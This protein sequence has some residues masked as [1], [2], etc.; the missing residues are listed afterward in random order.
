MALFTYSCSKIG[1]LQLRLCMLLL[2]TAALIH[3]KSN[4][5]NDVQS[6]QLADDRTSIAIH[7]SIIKALRLAAPKEEGRTW[8]DTSLAF[9]SDWLFPTTD[10]LWGVSASTLP[11]NEPCTNGPGCDPD[12]HRLVCTTNADCIDPG[13]NCAP[14]LATVKKPGDVPLNLCQYPSDSMVDG[15]YKIMT[16]AEERLDIVSLAAPSGIFVSA[17]NNAL[18]FLSHRNSFTEVRILY[19]GEVTRKLN[20]NQPPSAYLSTLLAGLTKSGAKLETLKIDVGWLS[21]KKALSWNH[22]KLIIADQKIVLQGGHNLWDPDYIGLRPVSDMSMIGT[23]AGVVASEKFVD[24]LWSFVQGAAVHPSQ[25]KV[26]KPFADAVVPQRQ[27]G[28]LSVLA[29]GRLGAYNNGVLYPAS[30]GQESKQSSD[31]ALRALIDAA[32][33]EV[34]IAQQDLYNL[35]TKK[36]PL[37]DFST[38]EVVG[39]FGASYAAT[40]IA[41]AVLRGVKFNIIQSNAGTDPV[42]DYGTVSATDAFTAL[43]GKIEKVAA[44]IK[45]IPPPGKTLRAY[46]CSQ[47]NYA[48]FR[49][50]PS[51]DKWA[52]GTTIGNHTK[53][54]IADRAAFYIGSHNL[55]PFDLQEFGMITFD[56]AR[57]EELIK[58]YWVPA[59]AGSSPSKI[60]CPSGA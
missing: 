34:L 9:S 29:V 20:I 40:N 23:G 5:A 7:D 43:V 53:I 1:R 47:V 6:A 30:R 4:S 12:F 19:S 3:C 22:A 32:Q 8:F 51:W 59:W 36:G 17:I 52:N 33:T 60:A 25:G 11:V 45:F 14:L 21:S 56:V 57:A 18:S 13:L 46:I 41:Q 44:E 50:S 35:I 48:P 39:R 58:R 55:Y 54:V 37:I 15:V 27:P 42:N 2:C 49:Y 24:L 26:S 10:K 38:N 16:Q 28:E 31:E